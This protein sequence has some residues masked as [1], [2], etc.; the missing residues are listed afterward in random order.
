MKDN[1]QSPDLKKLLRRMKLSPMLETLP[2]RLILARQQKMSHESFLELVMADEVQRRETLSTRTRA[3]KAK[4]DQA[5]VM[6][7]W[8]DTAKVTFDHDLWGELQTLR[9][10]ENRH[11]VL[12]LGPVG[13]GKSFIGNALAYIAC[14]RGMSALM[15]RTDKLLKELKASRLDHTYE[16]ELRKCYSV[17]LL[18]LDDFGIDQLDAT[19]SRDIY[20]II[21]ERHRVGSTIVT[22]NRDPQEWLGTMT[23]PLRAQSAIDRLQNSAYE[24]V[25]EGESYRKRQKPAWKGNDANP[26]Q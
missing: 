3:R 2:E 1:N 16:Q 6:E 11:N 15:L 22:S 19:E 18:V 7:A 14:R 8:D 5:M 20:E 12:I 26:K 13:V 25:I 10:I 17:D 9:F 21:F 24:L 23:D 4:L